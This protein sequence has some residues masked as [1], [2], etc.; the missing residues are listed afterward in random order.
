MIVVPVRRCCVCWRAPHVPTTHRHHVHVS[1]VDDV[2]HYGS[3]F[4]QDLALVASLDVA[5]EFVLSDERHAD[6]RGVAGDLSI[7]QVLG[8][9]RGD[10]VARH[11]VCLCIVSGYFGKI[12]AQL[13]RRHLGL[14]VPILLQRSNLQEHPLVRN[15][16]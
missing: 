15:E 11:E 7:G 5:C 10:L 2:V 8:L 12:F 6:R 16:N 1:S 13:G 3:D 9:Y 14:Y 4:R